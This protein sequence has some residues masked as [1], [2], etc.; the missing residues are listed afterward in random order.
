M[1]FVV[2]ENLQLHELI[3]GHVMFINELELRSECTIDT[4]VYNTVIN[5]LCRHCTHG[6]TFLALLHGKV[7]FLVCNTVKL[8]TRPGDKATV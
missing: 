4:Y 2:S 6:H 1:E 5:I 3:C 8:R 7:S